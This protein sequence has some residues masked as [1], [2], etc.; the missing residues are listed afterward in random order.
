[1]YGEIV[2]VNGGNIKFAGEEFA[3]YIYCTVFKMNGGDIAFSGRGHN[4]AIDAGLI[5]INDGS[6]VSLG[7][8]RYD[9]ITGYDF[10]MNGGSINIVLECKYGN[11]PSAI[12]GS[13]SLVVND[14][15]IVIKYEDPEEGTECSGYSPFETKIELDINGGNIF[16]IRSDKIVSI[17]GKDIFRIYK[18]YSDYEEGTGTIKVSDKAKI[19]DAKS[20]DISNFKS[21]LEYTECTYDGK[22]KTPKVYVDGLVEGENYTVEYI[23]NTN[24][25]IAKVVVTGKGY[26]TGKSILTFLI[27]EKTADGPKKGATVKD[28]KYIYKVTKAGSKDGKIIG[29]LSVTGLKKKTLKAIKI[30]ANVKIGGV[31]YK[32]TSIGAKAFKGNKKITKATIGKNV[33]TIGASAFAKCTKIAQVTINAKGLKSIGKNAFNGDKKLK[34]VIIKSTKLKKIGKKAFLRKGG[35]KIVF[36]V[37]KS[38]KKAYKKLLKK[39]KTNKFKI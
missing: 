37:P 38:K 35:K 24:V 30:A 15:T 4:S 10:E 21:Y 22:A 2:I 13:N 27:K 29:E 17:I 7:D 25:G 1:M 18:E 36:K 8:I 6:I 31:T 12:Y 9:T 11:Y 20:I 23:G 33:K 14:G 39:A 16:V 26:V 3:D 5:I 19:I 32:V 28:K 34:K